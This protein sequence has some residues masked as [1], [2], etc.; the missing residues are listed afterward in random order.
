M[1]QTVL[2]SRKDAGMWAEKGRRAAARDN[3]KMPTSLGA[4]LIASLF[5]NLKVNGSTT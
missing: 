2:S 1:D 4:V 3:L 5:T